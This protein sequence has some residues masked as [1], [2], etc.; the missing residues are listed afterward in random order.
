MIRDPKVFAGLC[1][2]APR[3]RVLPDRSNSGV[4]DSKT[5]RYPDLQEPNISYYRA[6][7]REYLTCEIITAKIEDSEGA[8]HIAIT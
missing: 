4:A 8:K 3:H 2:L 7:D 1:F 6:V 5:R